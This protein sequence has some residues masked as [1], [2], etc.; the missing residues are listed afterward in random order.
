[1]FTIIWNNT[2]TA[3]WLPKGPD[4][5]D[6]LNLSANIFYEFI[7]F[8]CSLFLIFVNIVFDFSYFTIT[9]KSF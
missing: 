8:P 7:F 2:S 3:P 6:N 1:M 5:T 9:G 4:R